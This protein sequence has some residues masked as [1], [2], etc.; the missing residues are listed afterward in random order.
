MKRASERDGE[1]KVLHK[2]TTLRPNA[3]TFEVSGV[4]AVRELARRGDGIHQTR[5]NP[6]S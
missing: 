5:R 6:L 1:R 3:P 4:E 2:R